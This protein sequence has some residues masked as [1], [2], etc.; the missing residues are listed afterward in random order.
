MRRNIRARFQ[1]HAISLEISRD[2]AAVLETVHD[3]RES[4]C[5]SKSKRMAALMK[6]GQVDDRVAKQRIAAGGASA[7]QHVNDSAPFAVD[8]DRLGLP[9][10]ARS[11]GSPVE[12]QTRVLFGGAFS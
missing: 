7:G 11:P 6:A 4:A 3:I 5:M 1:K 9:V 8:H 12:A 10:E 2:I